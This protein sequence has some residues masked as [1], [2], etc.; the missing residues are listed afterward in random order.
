MGPFFPADVVVCGAYVLPYEPELR[1]ESR[2]F[3]CIGGLSKSGSLLLSLK[4]GGVVDA[5][6]VCAKCLLK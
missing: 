3:L 2:C 4:L 5:T 1:K 6:G